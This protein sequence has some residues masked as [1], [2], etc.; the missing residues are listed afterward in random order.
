[1]NKD[2]EAINNFLAW[3]L[4]STT[5]TEMSSGESS[6]R[7]TGWSDSTAADLQFD[8]ID[9]LDSEE[10]RVLPTD[11]AGST[12]FSF[13]EM[14][15]FRPG[16][17]PAVQDRFH[18]LLKRRLRSEIERKPPLFPWESEVYEY[19]SEVPDLV[20]S[21]LVPT[22][23]W[24]TQLKNL[25]LP[26]P[27]PEAVLAQLF[28]RCQELVQSSLQEGVKLVRA[29]ESFF[30]GHAQALNNLAPLAMAVQREAKDGDQ[31]K[32]PTPAPGFPSHYEVATQPQQMVLSLLAAREIMDSLKLV[33]SPARP[34]AERQ[35]ITNFGPL[36]LSVEYS[37]SSEQLRVHAQLP[38]A[39]N[40][41]IEGG[42]A[43]ATAQ[44]STLGA[45]SVELFDVAPN[46]TY[47]LEV[48]LGVD[49][50]PLVFVVQPKLD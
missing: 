36:T 33:A 12:P 15:S 24:V 14:S 44:R 5:S 3:L 28:E 40:I 10:I 4:Q 37:V 7:G 20:P 25:N 22:T 47:T 31:P 29:V 35:W 34:K 21:G 50:V 38:N 17:I 30:P 39:G 27:M 49:Q 26:V 46:Q 8:S 42:E 1:M 16:D 11:L 2:L 9:P 6:M 19:E 32:Y 13:P 41:R 18:T 43:Q 48:R 23:P 45:L